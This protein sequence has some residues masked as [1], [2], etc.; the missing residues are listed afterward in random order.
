MIDKVAIKK[1]L[2]KVKSL[3]II[4]QFRFPVKNNLTT[5]R[6]DERPDHQIGQDQMGLFFYDYYKR[7]DFLSH[8]IDINVDEEIER[9]VDFINGSVDQINIYHY[10]LIPQKTANDV[11]LSKFH[12]AQLDDR[13]FSLLKNTHHSIAHCLTQ[14]NFPDGYRFLLISKEIA[15]RKN[16]QNKHLWFDRLDEI[17]SF[18]TIVP[19][20]LKYYSGGIH[21]SI[22][23]VNTDNFPHASSS[24]SSN[25]FQSEIGYLDNTAISEIDT[26]VRFLSNKLAYRLIVRS[27]I[28]ANGAFERAI[29]LRSVIDPILRENKTV[30]NQAT[31]PGN[32]KTST[33]A[34]FILKTLSDNDAEHK[35][36]IDEDLLAQFLQIRNSIIHPD[37][38]ESIEKLHLLYDRTDDLR[39][40]IYSFL[41]TTIKLNRI[42]S[43]REFAL[44]TEL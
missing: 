23:S 12:T 22:H 20:L 28:S 32:N 25:L 1:Y 31:T 7:C 13:S 19:F 17:Y 24:G 8:I 36:L 38:S 4:D 16:H 43:Q 44:P 33:Q 29:F 40:V 26:I 37:P 15:N 27:E 34:K 39:K 42:G 41:I 21:S 18:H 5:I 3:S 6:V 30:I 9:M 2:S 14:E 10:S 35:D 11:S